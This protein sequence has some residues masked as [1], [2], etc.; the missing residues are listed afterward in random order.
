MRRPRTN[1][2]MLVT[3][4]LPALTEF[5]QGGDNVSA[6]LAQSAYM[7]LL[8]HEGMTEKELAADFDL[9]TNHVIKLRHRFMILGLPGLQRPARAVC[10]NHNS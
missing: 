5:A 10:G 6:E 9:P 8:L 4:W 1:F 7:I 2:P 3:K